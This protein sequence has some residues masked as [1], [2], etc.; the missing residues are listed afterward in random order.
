MR[1][2][3]SALVLCICFALLTTFGMAQSQGRAVERSYV[4]T[5][6]GV[7]VAGE[8]IY[9]SAF[10]FDIADRSSVAATSSPEGTSS[11]RS[12]VLSNLSN[13]LYL[14]LHSGEGMVQ[15]AKMALVGGRGACSLSIPATTPT[16]NYK[17]IAYTA[18]NKNEVGYS[19]DNMAS[20]TLSI[21]NTLTTERVKNGVE[22]VENERY[23]S[24]AV[25]VAEGGFSDRGAS[26]GGVSIDL[27]QNAKVGVSSSIPI[28][29]SSSL[30]ECTS[31]SVAVF[32]EDEIA[33]P[34]YA[35][36][37]DFVGAI[38]GEDATK[39]K[40]ENVAIPEYD[41]EIIAARLVTPKGEVKG[42]FSHSYGYFSVPGGMSDVYVSKIYDDSKLL[43]FTN[44]IYGQREV[45]CQ[46]G[47]SA[48][49]ESAH[50]E[51]ISPFV[52]AKVGK[53][54]PLILSDR[55]EQALLERSMGMQIEKRFAA[56]T[57]FEYL[58]IREMP[59]LSEVPI[60]YALDDYTRFPLME[61]VI[62][63]FVSQ[64]RAQ[65]ERGGEVDLQIRQE[66]AFG[67]GNTMYF[68]N[69][70]SLILVDGVP[71]LD[72]AKV[73]GYDPLLVKSISI[74]PYTYTIGDRL[75][76]GVANFTTYKGN[77]PS[78][79]FDDNV[80]IVNFQG[81]SYPL[82]YTCGSAI[83]ST[84]YPDYRQTIY[85]HPIVDLAAESSFNFECKTPDYA[86]KFVIVVEGISQSGEPIY[87][88]SSFEV[89]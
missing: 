41:G 85:W 52:K 5:D 28:T 53:I 88:R 20:K 65:K 83:G 42:D 70:T 37:S 16:G 18:Q 59:L 8:E 4:S 51:L 73:L 26:A 60:E 40:F 19:Y 61:E 76:E 45:V 62:V 64:I 17:L 23:D 55:L 57:L 30:K 84:S 6:K 89:K 72:H 74:Y 29:L 46:L 69:N 56:D 49:L 7:Y 15:S 24:L 22:I 10:C 47:G 13:V 80:R 39:V 34:N 68:S 82:A 12:A 75:F 27:P 67:S 14:E 78:I 50:I 33:A 44:N 2:E 58:P 32:H 3:I 9:C 63:E 43:F 71:V 86:G 79:S 1:K 54:D 35:D 38:K 66:D 87:C 77:L 31:L 36:I 25:A 81:V 48:A 21:F 11:V